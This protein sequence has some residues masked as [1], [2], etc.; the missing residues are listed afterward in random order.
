VKARIPKLKSKIELVALWRRGL[1]E[2]VGLEI[3]AHQ[4]TFRVVVF[5]EKNNCISLVRNKVDVIS[6]RCSAWFLNEKTTRSD[7]I[8]QVLN[9]N[10]LCSFTGLLND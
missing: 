8:E 6:M 4:G 10:S 3:E 2:L 1:A 9:D 7:Q 5:L